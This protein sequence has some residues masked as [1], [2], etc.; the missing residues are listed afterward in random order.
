MFECLP[1]YMS[2]YHV[3][4]WCPQRPEED[5]GDPGTRVVGGSEPPCQCW[6]LKLSPLEGQPVLLPLSHLSSPY[7]LVS[8]LFLHTQRIS[9]CGQAWGSTSTWGHVRH[10]TGVGLGGGGIT[11]PLWPLSY[12]SLFRETI[13]TLGSFCYCVV[14]GTFQSCDV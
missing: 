13:F 9:P 7:S 5:V 8:M 3:R 4:A 6:E 10:D 1:T 11:R 12:L 14:A 2:M